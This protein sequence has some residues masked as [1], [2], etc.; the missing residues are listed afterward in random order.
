[1]S[2]RLQIPVSDAEYRQIQRAARSER[3]S[4]AEW[5]RRALRAAIRVIPSGDRDRKLASIRAAAVHRFPTADI[6]RMLA[7]IELGYGEGA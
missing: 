5:A 4:S 3:V 6:D 1:M 7:E 2:K